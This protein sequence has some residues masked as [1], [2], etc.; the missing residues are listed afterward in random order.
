MCLLFRRTSSGTT[1]NPLNLLAQNTLTFSLTGTHTF[2]PLCLSLQKPRIFFVVTVY[3]PF[4]KLYDFICHGIQKI[5]V[6]RHHNQG[7]T[8]RLQLI[9]QPIRHL[10]VQMVCRLIQYEHITWS[11]Q[12]GNKC[13]TLSLSTG[14]LSCLLFKVCNTKPCKHCLSRYQFIF[15]GM[16]MHH[17]LNTL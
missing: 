7:P 3:F 1:R 2:F 13:K 17:V 11:N 12:H 5:P 8:E 14:K 10:T 16:V 9:F 15:I 6:M 4:V